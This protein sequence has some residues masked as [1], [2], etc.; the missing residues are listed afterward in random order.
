MPCY[1][2]E[3]YDTERAN[4]QVQVLTRLLCEACQ[5][6]DW[7]KN[8]GKATDTLVSWW[9]KHQKDDNDRA[10]EREREI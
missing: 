8:L 9:D 2:P 1:D 6:I 5:L 3:R 7:D 4:Q 10:R